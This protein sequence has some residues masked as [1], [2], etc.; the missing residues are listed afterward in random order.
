MQRTIATTHDKLQAL[1][2]EHAVVTQDA[3]GAVM[4]TLDPFVEAGSKLYDELLAGFSHALGPERHA[5]FVT[6]GTEQ[7][8]R[9]LGRFGV[10]QRTL[11]VTRDPASDHRHY[12]VW[13]EQA[14]AGNRGATTGNYRS[15]EEL[16]SRVGAI[17]N[18]LPADF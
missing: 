9:A 5:A 4:I 15:R 1:E 12:M 14:W 18:L 8:D 10:V 3:N 13:D 2:R 16:M 17:M 7:V 6:L 11:T